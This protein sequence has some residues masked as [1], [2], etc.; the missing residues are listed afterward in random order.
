MKAIPSFETSVSNKKAT[1]GNI[2]KIGTIDEKDVRFI[3][4]AYIYIYIYIYI[5]NQY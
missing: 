5:Y 3:S 1:Q 4:V 2:Q